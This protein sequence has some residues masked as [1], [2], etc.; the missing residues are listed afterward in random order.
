MRYRK[1]SALISD[2]SQLGLTVTTPRS[3]LEESWDVWG[4]RED[5]ITSQQR[6]IVIARLL[7]EQDAWVRSVGVVDLLSSL[8]RDHALYLDEEF[9]ER[10][11]DRFTQTDRDLVTFVQRYLSTIEAMNLI[12]PAFALRLLAE[13]LHFSEIEVR[14]NSVLPAFWEEFFCRVA[15]SVLI[16]DETIDPGGP[17]VSLDDNGG[18]GSSKEIEMMRCLDRDLLLLKP[19]GD[20]AKGKLI[21]DC[22]QAIEDAPFVLITSPDPSALFFQ[23]KTVLCQ[24]GF[25]VS[26]QSTRPF[27]ST[28]F[29]QAYAQVAQLLE[30]DESV[31]HEVA[32]EA[33]CTF[34][35]SPYAQVSE[36]IAD[37]IQYALRHDRTLSRPEMRSVLRSA[38]HSF[39]FFE[40]LFEEADAD[41]LLSYFE[42]MLGGLSLT[43]SQRNAERATISALRDVYRDARRFSVA[44]RDL[45]DL[46]YRTSVPYTETLASVESLDA[47][48]L[49][50]GTLPPFGEEDIE[51]QGS[52]AKQEDPM[53]ASGAYAVPRVLI[54]ALDTAAAF[55]PN[56]FDQVIMTDLDSSHYSGEQK[57][58]TV[59]S[60]LERFELPR[61]D[62]EALHLEM[63][64]LRVCDLARKQV[65]FEY[66]AKD[67]DGNELY[68]TFFLEAL[69]ADRKQAGKEVHQEDR[70]EAMIDLNAR[71]VAIEEGD[72]RV[73]PRVVRGQLG[74]TASDELLQWAPDSQGRLRPVLSPSAIEVYRKCPYRW[75]VERKLHLEDGEESFGALERGSFIHSVFQLFYDR[76][77]EEGFD[78]ITPA[79]HVQAEHLFFELFDDLV[80]EQRMKEPGDRYVATDQLEFQEVKQLGD[81]L[82]DSLR[83]QAHMLPNYHIEGHEVTLEPEEGIEYAGALI[84]G[85][86]D[87]IDVNDRGD[88]VIIDYKGSTRD[89][90]GGYSIPDE[91][92]EDDEQPLVAPE[93]IQALIYAQALRKRDPERSPKGALYLSYKAKKPSD[94]LCGSVA[95]SLIEAAPFTKKASIVEG[96]F[97]HFLDLVEQ[98]LTS[99]VEH[100]IAG[101]IAPDPRT[102]EACKYCPVLYCE[103]RR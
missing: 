8:V 36:D 72:I 99:T 63:T 89:H 35:C 93:R 55:P 71:I 45:L 97:E 74:Q 5:I 76:L 47:F 13:S 34:I 15:D 62:D 86:V 50:Q 16:F 33:A 32:L 77:A 54:T 46:I 31:S 65:V 40:D 6:D 59:T 80:K 60:F 30:H 41:V 51:T 2:K 66:S 58:T 69:L 20:S 82:R 95:E 1:K 25:V 83:Y 64:F 56:S 61:R 84:R 81:Q 29:G 37:R 19:A 53:D 98:E 28:D 26:L 67:R 100:M 70:G 17:D 23:L 39:E 75:F 96:D 91:L 57:H 10:N 90:V 103:K 7:A 21:A 43:D 9:C 85:R 78:R 14:T 101:D 12:E 4:S 3:F 48:D 24:R 73:L 68:P 18:N 102:K 22:L 87:R 49:Q 44:L 27:L 11:D 42:D 92:P 79:D 88:Y 94:V 52:S 38:S